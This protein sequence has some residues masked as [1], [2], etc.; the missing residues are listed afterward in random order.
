M[1]FP[2]FAEALRRALNSRPRRRPSIKRSERFEDRTLLSAVSSTI[3]L[4]S[5]SLPAPTNNSTGGDDT[6]ELQAVSGD[7]RYVAFTSSA[8]NLIAADTDSYNDVYVHDTLTGQLEL[9]SVDSL[10]VKGNNDSSRPSISADGRYVAFTSSATNLVAGDTNGRNDIFIHDRLTG[11][12]QRILGAG[13][14]QS[15]HHSDFASLSDDGQFVAFQ[16]RASNLVAGAD[17]NDGQTGSFPSGGFVFTGPDDSDVFVASVASSEVVDRISETAGGTSGDRSSF[18]PS[19]SADGRYVAYTSWA[20]NLTAGDAN[21]TVDILVHDRVTNTTQRISAGTGQAASPTISDDGQFVAYLEANPVFEN[22]SLNIAQAYLTDVA[23]GT[24]VM[25]S[26]DGIGNA[27][28]QRAVIPQISGNG[29]YVAFTT[30]STNLG[31]PATGQKL[32]L[33]DS[34]L[35]QNLL[36]SG[37]TA[38]ISAITASVSVDGKTVA[39]STDAGLDAGDTG[40][41]DVYRIDWNR[42]PDALGNT[43]STNE[44]TAISAA[45]L[46]VT[47]DDGDALTITVTQAPLHGQLTVNPDGT[48]DYVPDADY[49]GPDEFRYTASDGDATSGE[50]IVTLNVASVNDAPVVT[51]GMFTVDETDAPGTVVGQVTS[52]DVE[53]DTVTYAIT[54]GNTGGQFAIN[55]ATGEI[56]VAGPLTVG[57][58]ILTVIATDTQGGVGAAAVNIDVL[59]TATGTGVTAPTDP[60]NANKPFFELVINGSTNLDV[61]QIDL[62]SLRT[63]IL[64]TE[65]SLRRKGNGDLFV[66]FKDFDGDGDL[67]LEVRVNLDLTG[68]TTGTNTGILTGSLLNQ[69]TFTLLYTIDIA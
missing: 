38:A 27:G 26:Q 50:A 62:D 42:G 30:G 10:G 63:G 49:F 64:G 21:G 2:S 69:T 41:T 20:T 5:E 55:P 19:L 66:K 40:E 59:P 32:F 48:F 46:G 7:G 1:F 61:T 24:T 56:T 16:S 65:D 39:I 33:Y 15:N 17:L 34:A 25:V 52:T 12:T 23:N 13:G 18:S 22:P 58:A 47:D 29:R 44:D 28:N 60:I 6:S 54:A 8:S 51:G 67:D 68:F 45:S 4:V 36:L 14:V 35:Q 11:T 43:V 53:L 57:S 31:D 3:S 9:I 37:G